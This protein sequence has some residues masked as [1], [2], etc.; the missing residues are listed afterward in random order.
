MR[1]LRTDDGQATAVD[2]ATGSIVWSTHTVRATQRHSG[3]RRVPGR[4][5]ATRTITVSSFL[6]STTGAPYRS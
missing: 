6:T 1:S 3:R 2:A 5:T 4:S